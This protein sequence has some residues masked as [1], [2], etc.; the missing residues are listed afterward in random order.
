MRLGR[1][2]GGGEARLPRMGSRLVLVDAEWLVSDLSLEEVS[3]LM[4]AGDLIPAQRT[5][6]RLV[7]NPAH[8]VFVEDWTIPPP[9]P[10]KD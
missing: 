10:A 1:D 7:V 9:P 5:G 3:A 4:R 8:V 2:V 6:K